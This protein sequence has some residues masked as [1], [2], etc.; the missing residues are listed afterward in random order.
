MINGLHSLPRRDQRTL[1]SGSSLQG[2]NP[3]RYSNLGHFA[4]SLRRTSNNNRI[5]LAFV[6]AHRRCAVDVSAGPAFAK[7]NLT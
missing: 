7:Q 2:L 3:C 5:A 1:P 6:V 4:G